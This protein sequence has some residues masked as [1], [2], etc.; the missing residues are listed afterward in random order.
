MPEER[1][2]PEK[3]TLSD[4]LALETLRPLATRYVA[5]TAWSMRPAAV[6]S[7]LNEI[8]V[9][10]RRSVLELGS[11]T[12][13]FFIAQALRETGGR[14]LSV[15]HDVAWAEYVERVLKQEGLTDVAEVAVVPLAV[16]ARSPQEPPWYD[17]ELLQKLAP[18][19][20]DLLIVDGPPAGPYPD[21]LVREPAA[22]ILKP[23]L[24][25]DGCTVVLDDLDRE[26]ERATL[27]RWEVELDMPFTV[28]SRISLG[29][30]RSDGGFA[31][32]L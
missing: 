27:E 31:P 30:G 4:L 6:A 28:I 7:V 14:L 11:G 29:I 22:K 16:D 23:R 24:A 3:W 20:V 21:E 2:A 32:T 25:K 12:S 15:E 17:H 26:A 1:P 8:Y 5:W 19:E 10:G 18:D 9:T 13:T